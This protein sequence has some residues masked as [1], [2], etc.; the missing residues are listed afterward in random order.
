LETIDLTAPKKRESVDRLDPAARGAFFVS[1]ALSGSKNL[2]AAKNDLE[3][4]KRYLERQRRSANAGTPK[5]SIRA[6]AGC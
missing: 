3:G 5:P 1:L 4:R 2:G 6:S